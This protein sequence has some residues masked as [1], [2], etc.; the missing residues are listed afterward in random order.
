MKQ[1]R[2]DSRRFAVG[3][4]SFILALQIFFA[5]NLLHA[6]QKEEKP[7]W[8][9]GIAGISGY[10]ADYPAAET[11]HPKGIILPYVVYR[12]EIFRAG[13]RGIARGRIFHNDRVEFDLSLGGSFD[14]ES[15]EDGVR[16]GMPDL[17]YLF[18][19]GPR[20]QVILSK[21]GKNEK[22]EFE[23]PARAV[24]STDF[25]SVSNEGLLIA[26]SISWQH[27]DFQ[28]TGAELKVSFGPIFAS[29]DF[30]DYFYE[31]APRFATPQRP[32]FDA[33]SG[34][35]GCE[36]AVR[37]LKKIQDDLAL[38]GTIELGYYGGAANHDSP[39]FRQDLNVNVRIG[40]MWTPFH[41]R[42]SVQ[43]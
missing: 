6:G 18:E 30:M 34:Y 28:G 37:T 35:H 43:E 13:E 9:L 33:K 4:V 11:N 12:G 40:F 38:F 14:T 19:I 22:V 16:H 8:E 1:V 26:P 39:L 42:K 3:I 20:L 25:S 21:K 7:L 31:V 24:M 15:D 36:T 17:D 2:T 32:A 29:E 10:V 41:S 27:A 23:L 5:G